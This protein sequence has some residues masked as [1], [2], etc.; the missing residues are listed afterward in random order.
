MNYIK[1]KNRYNDVFTFTET[2]DGNILWEG[3]FEYCRFGSPN[4]YTNAYK[5][6]LTDEPPHDHLLTLSEFKKAIHKYNKETYES[7]ELSKKYSHLIYSDIKTIN[8][9][10]P[11]GGPCLSEG[12]NLSY[13]SDKFKDK[14]IQ[15]FENAETGYLIKV[16]L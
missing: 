4:V 16:K 6:Y 5:A 3:N 2:K 15:S 8:M 10:D 12:Y 14:I 11:S 1:Y 9:V 13:L 7:S